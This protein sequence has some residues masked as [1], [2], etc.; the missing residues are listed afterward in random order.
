MI[1]TEGDVANEWFVETGG[2]DTELVIQALS[3]IEENGS[4]SANLIGVFERLHYDAA[5]DCVGVCKVVDPTG[6]VDETNL[7][8]GDG[9]LRNLRWRLCRRSCRRRFRRLR[10][11]V[12]GSLHAA[13]VVV[14]DAVATI[15]LSR[16]R[17]LA[18]HLVFL[19][20]FSIGFTIG[21]GFEQR[22]S[23]HGHGT[24]E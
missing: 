6:I 16:S 23:R 1:G 2:S 4:D 9:L 8:L 19:L 11:I 7:I 12:D 20:T 17:L 21:Y 22:A 24:C 10:S 15:S 18:G 3:G 14:A 13:G 5:G